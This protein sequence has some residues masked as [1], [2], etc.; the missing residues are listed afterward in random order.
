MVQA[1]KRSVLIDV[2]YKSLQRFFRSELAEA[3]IYSQDG[4]QP[5]CSS[6]AHGALLCATGC[7]QA[8]QAH[9]ELR[10]LVTLARPDLALCEPLHPNCLH[11]LSAWHAL[12]FSQVGDILHF[13]IRDLDT[14]FGDMLL[15]VHS[16]AAGRESRADPAGAG[17]RHRHAHCR[18]VDVL[19]LA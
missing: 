17:T 9:H 11:I 4:K 18:P 12:S 19:V 14:I 16:L 6:R 10:C 7:F 5:R 2:G 1:D 8:L 13:T 3:P 15:D